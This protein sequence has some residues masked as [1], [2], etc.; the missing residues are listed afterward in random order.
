MA[1]SSQSA[2]SSP[3]SSTFVQPVA[4]SQASVVQPSPSSQNSGCGVRQVPVAGSHV[5]S[6]SQA[7]PLLQPNAWAVGAARQAPL[8]H[9]P[10]PVQALPS[11][12]RPVNIGYWQPEIGLQDSLVHGLASS[13]LSVV[14]S[15][16]PLTVL[17]C[18]VGPHTLPAPMALQACAAAVTIPTHRPPTQVSPSVHALVSLHAAVLFV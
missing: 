13:Q 14:M 17:Q 5:S 11:S 2:P 1:S 8:T 4:G 10:G 6:P 7:F 18:P 15:H 12:H 3:G 16:R 9:S